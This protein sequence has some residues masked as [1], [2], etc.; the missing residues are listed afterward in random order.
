MSL[1][2]NTVGTAAG[3]NDCRPKGR[4]RRQM[5]RTHGAVASIVVALVVAGCG[6]SVGASGNNASKPSSKT[7]GT[8]ASSSGA[9]STPVTI[10]LVKTPLSWL[11]WVAIK[12]GFFGRNGVQATPVVYQSG[13]QGIEGVASG[14]IKVNIGLDLGTVGAAYEKGI[15]ESMLSAA[16]VDPFSIVGAG[17]P[18]NAAATQF[19]AGIK[20]IAGKTIVIVA[21]G[22][23]TQSAIQE[24]D[25]LAGLGPSAM[26]FVAAGT[27]AGVSAALESHRAQY[28]VVDAGMIAQLE[29]AKF[30]FYTIV[31]M[32]QPLKG[33]QAATPAGQEANK[34]IGRPVLGAWAA[35]TWV[36]SHEAEV[37]KIQLSLEEADCWAHTPGN[38]GKLTSML[39]SLGMIPPGLS[40]QQTKSYVGKD[41]PESYISASDFNTWNQLLVKIGYLKSPLPQTMLANG[42]PSSASAV[43]Q[44]VTAAG[45]ACPGYSS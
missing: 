6:S 19:P 7:Q 22:T 20:E 37:Q 23:A 8:A 32:R 31:D 41:L 16:G 12:E 29:S 11:G 9:G 28:A 30:P 4:R 21:A 45:V 38:L 33:T 1:S 3:P 27:V 17:S 44:A 42:A 39:N 13:P 26:K 24:L 10:G 35:P 18:P 36:A 14:S 5:R 2:P 40:A 25:E 15:K 34:V 43:Y